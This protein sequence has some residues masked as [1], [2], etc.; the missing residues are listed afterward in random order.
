MNYTSQLRKV[1]RPLN[2]GPSLKIGGTLDSEEVISYF[3]SFVSSIL[4]R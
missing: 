3:L 4:S 1:N 2:C